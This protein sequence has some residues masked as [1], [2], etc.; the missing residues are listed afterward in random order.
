M[1]QLHNRCCE[2]L[3]ENISPSSDKRDTIIGIEL[4]LAKNVKY[5]HEGIKHE[6]THVSDP[7]TSTSGEKVYIQDGPKGGTNGAYN[8][9]MRNSCVCEGYTRAMQYLLKLK[10]IHSHN[11]DC[12]LT[13]D[14][15]GMSKKGE[16]TQYTTYILPSFDNY[17]SIICIDDYFGLYADP[18]NNAAL[19]RPGSNSLRWAL[20]TKKEISKTHTLSFDERRIDNDHLQVPGKEIEGSVRRNDLFANTRASQVEIQRGSLR[21][22]RGQITKGEE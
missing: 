22:I 5:D 8:A 2:I 14:V 21:R 16:E 3:D 17:H 15:T 18:C 13:E 11:V 7:I 9:I 12:F 19:Y 1:I 6:Y 20:C 10:G 4:Y